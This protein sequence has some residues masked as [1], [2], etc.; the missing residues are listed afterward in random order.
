MVSDNVLAEVTADRLAHTLTA[1]SAELIGV[2]DTVRSLLDDIVER[3]AA[4]AAAAL[5]PDGDR[6]RVIGGTGLRTTE[7]HLVLDA[8]HWLVA[9]IALAGQAIL[10]ED[11]DTV[12]LRVEGAPLAGWRRLMA[13]PIP[14]TRTTILLARGDQAATFN[15]QDLA[16]IVGPVR[17]AATTLSAALATRELARALGPFQEYPPPV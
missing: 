17:R 5:V 3:A 2:R 14:E 13:V 1:R 8:D 12:R 15:D 11:T 7:H 10:I 4:D 9:D 6:W 16:A